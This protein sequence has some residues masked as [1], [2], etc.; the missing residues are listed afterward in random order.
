VFT[1]LSCDFNFRLS[2]SGG[3]GL[4]QNTLPN[5]NVETERTIVRWCKNWWLKKRRGRY[6]PS[7]SGWKYQ[8]AASYRMEMISVPEVEWPLFRQLGIV[9]CGAAAACIR[10][11]QLTSDYAS[12]MQQRP[13]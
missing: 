3:S 7:L 1:V 11:L 12:A 4:M 10:E 2:L 13:N 9:R 6:Q 5:T 8:M